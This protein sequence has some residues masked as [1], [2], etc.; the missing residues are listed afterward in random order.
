MENNSKQFSEARLTLTALMSN[1]VDILL[2]IWHLYSQ[3]LKI[4][5]AFNFETP[6][7]IGAYISQM[8]QISSHLK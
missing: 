1:T 2:F 4:K 7:Y 3:L 5:N 8:T 6:I